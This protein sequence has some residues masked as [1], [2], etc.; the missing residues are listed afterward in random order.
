MPGLAVAL[1]RG[2]DEADKITDPIG[3]ALKRTTTFKG[4]GRKV[5]IVSTP[6]N[7]GSRINAWYLRGKEFLEVFLNPTETMQIAAAG[8]AVL[9][10]N[11]G[12]LRS[13]RSAEESRTDRLRRALRRGR[14]ARIDLLRPA[15]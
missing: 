4:K 13:H 1:N 3:L 12:R 8:N 5:I 10:G 7:R 15:R 6:T 14:P 9:A 11:A 2:N